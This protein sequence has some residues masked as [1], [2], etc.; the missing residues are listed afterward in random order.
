MQAVIHLTTD[1]ALVIWYG[2]WALSM[3]GLAAVSYIGYRQ[4]REDLLGYLAYLFLW[5]A[6]DL[7]G[8]MILRMPVAWWLAESGLY[9]GRLAPIC[10]SAY[11]FLALDRFF[12]MNNGH[13][14]IPRRLL[15]WW[16]SRSQRW[17]DRQR[18]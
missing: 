11:G 17:E 10:W 3:L 13:L 2:C 4:H 8:R 12:A 18:A 9:L 16:D 1:W 7:M 14:D 6:L 15:R 5:M